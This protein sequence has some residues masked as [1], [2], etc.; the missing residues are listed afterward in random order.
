MKELI[1]LLV[2]CLILT[3]CV[4]INVPTTKVLSY[5]IG[6]EKNSS[7]S[8][9]NKIPHPVDGKITTKSTREWCG[10]TVWALIPIPLW[11]PV[12]KAH[13]DVTFINNEAVKVERSYPNS[14]LY[15]CGPFMPFLGVS[16]TPVGYCGSAN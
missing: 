16:G 14:K 2:T 5:N 4:G 12:C 6:N 8:A 9:W 7:A 1:P 11:L 10:Y 15:A 3:G 13:T